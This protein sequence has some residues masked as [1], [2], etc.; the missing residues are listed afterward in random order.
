[1]VK[2]LSAFARIYLLASI[3]YCNFFGGNSYLFLLNC[4]FWTLEY[5]TTFCIISDDRRG[6][7]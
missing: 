6:A 5:N 4:I 3:M 7:L 1:M 2:K